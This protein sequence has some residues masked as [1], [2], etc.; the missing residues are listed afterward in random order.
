MY[1]VK[2]TVDCDLLVLQQRY[3]LIILFSV[4]Q[5]IDRLRFMSGL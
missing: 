5:Q 2:L 1:R 4:L 3:Y